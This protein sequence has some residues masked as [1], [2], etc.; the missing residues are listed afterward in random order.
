[1]DPVAAIKRWLLCT[2]LRISVTG[3][4]ACYGGPLKPEVML[5]KQVRSCD[6]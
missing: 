6:M 2:P 3:H 1:V 4:F 5:E